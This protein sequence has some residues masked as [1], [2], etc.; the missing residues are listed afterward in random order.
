MRLLNDL[1]DNPLLKEV[2]GEKERD[3]EQVSNQLTPKTIA[4]DAIAA[5]KIPK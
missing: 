4:I 3:D 5:S 2:R 1:A